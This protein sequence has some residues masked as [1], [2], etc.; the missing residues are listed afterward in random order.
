MTSRSAKITTERPFYDLHAEAYDALITDPVESW[1]DAVHTE[2]ADAGMAS[3]SLLDAGCGTGRHAE[4]LLG[5]GHRV[6]L[7]DASP[8]LLEIAARRCPG[9]PAYLD[10]ICAPA[11][12]A[13]YDAIT[14]RGVLNDLVLDEERDAAFQSFAT[15]LVEGGLLILDVRE[16]ESSR[17]RADGQQRETRVSLEDGRQLLFA[18]R[19]SW[20]SERIL[21]EERYELSGHDETV[22][23]HEYVFE[24]RPWGA[25]EVEARLEMAGFHRVEVRPGVGGRWDRLFVTARCGA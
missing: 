15:L 4:A 8:R 25:S 6:S 3:G 17:Q 18:S 7:L 20:R 24:M 2:L 12:D 23:V 14:C 10:D 1:V 13:T 9:A 22:S 21:V 16:T 11:L 19:P 5:L